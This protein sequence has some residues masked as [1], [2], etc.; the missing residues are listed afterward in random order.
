MKKLLC[1]FAHPDDESFGPGG[2]LA[3]W[4]KQGVD[5]YL[6]CATKG[7]LGNNGTGRKT[8][9]I[10]EEELHAAAKILGIG[11]VEFLGY[12]DGKICNHEVV[13]LQKELMKQINK[14]KPDA[15]MTFDLNGASGHI[16][17]VS[18]ASATTYAFHKTSSPKE[19]YYFTYLKSYTDQV[20]DYFIH[21][22]EG[23]KSEA[24]D[25]IVNI[26]DVWEKKLAAMHAHQSQIQDVKQIL[27]IL[28][29]LPKEECFLVR[30]K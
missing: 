7:E 12:F 4:A 1:I 19:L 24:V 10:R 27:K 17:H 23:K 16:D 15:L 13:R 22:P 14:I 2:T 3:L 9:E 6:L 11:K 5:I 25:E 18:V 29:N 8:E 21:F 20:A 26:E 28:N 30:R